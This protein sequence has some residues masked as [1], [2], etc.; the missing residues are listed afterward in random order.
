MAGMVALV[1]DMVGCPGFYICKPVTTCSCKV[2]LLA[3]LPL[4]GFA[5]RLRA[6]ADA[7]LGLP[8]QLRALEAC[9]W[10]IDQRRARRCS[11]LQQGTS[12]FGTDVKEELVSTAGLVCR[13]VYG[14][15]SH[16]S[17]SKIVLGAITVGRLDS[18]APGCRRQG[19]HLVGN[20][21]P[22][23]WLALSR[24]FAPVPL[25]QYMSNIRGPRSLR[26]HIAAM[27]ICQRARFRPVAYS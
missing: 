20:Q 21:R 18:H 27:A 2:I 3:G 17:T 14:L 16:R 1:G 25:L 9:W 4:Y 22:S 15:W 19:Q 6:R 8:G 11:D 13:N 5:V 24:C 23:D 10:P 12:E 7:P 26:S